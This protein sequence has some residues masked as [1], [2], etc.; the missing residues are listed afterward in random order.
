MN[1]VE[2]KRTLVSRGIKNKIFSKG[3]F[4]NLKGIIG[5]YNENKVIAIRIKM[6]SLCK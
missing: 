4:I 1:L 3:F 5:D 6:Q 2:T